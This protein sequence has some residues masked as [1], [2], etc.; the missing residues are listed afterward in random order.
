MCRERI[1]SVCIHECY[2]HE[3]AGH[4]KCEV[5][6]SNWKRL[7]LKKEL[8]A[9]I[10]EYTC[11][12]YANEEEPLFKRKVKDFNSDGV[13]FTKSPNTYGSEINIPWDKKGHHYNQTFR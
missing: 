8:H 10:C 2:D 4:Q 13:I 1:P 9:V 12:R 6:R 5:A 3:Y 7:L 11:V